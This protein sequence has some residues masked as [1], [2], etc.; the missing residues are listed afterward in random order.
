MALN[1]VISA[2]T[3]ETPRFIVYGSQ[4]EN[5]NQAHTQHDSYTDLLPKVHRQ[6]KLDIAWNQQKAKS[7]YDKKRTDAPKIQVDS[8]VYLRRRTINKKE[9][10]IKSKRNSDKLDSVLLGPFRVESEL[11]NDNYRLELP[12]RMRIHPIFHVSLLKPTTNQGSE[13]EDEAFEEFSVE[14]ILP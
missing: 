14:A 9:Y 11:P 6:V 12:A 10:N 1:D 4:G 7:Y 3:N 13:R 2:T 8:F 5:T